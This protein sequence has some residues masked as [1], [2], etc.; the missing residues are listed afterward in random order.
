MP[1]A[2]AR[3]SKSGS[4]KTRSRL[5]SMS[6]SIVSDNVPPH[7]GPVGRC[8]PGG[9][10]RLIR[11]YTRT[12]HETRDKETFPQNPPAAVG[13]VGQR[14]ALLTYVSHCDAFF[15]VTVR[16]QRENAG[17]HGFE[18]RCASPI[19]LSPFRDSA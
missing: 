9:I 18:T 1:I 3:L 13:Q 7:D 16:T 2:I 15:P 19:P 5:L 14:A 10:D 17:C 11:F 12:S 8:E 6:C 4:L